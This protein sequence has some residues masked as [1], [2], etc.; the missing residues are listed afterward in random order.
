MRI[1]EVKFEDEGNNYGPDWCGIPTRYT[2]Y[3]DK[4]IVEL[5]GLSQSDREKLLELFGKDIE[6]KEKSEGF[7]GFNCHYEFKPFEVPYGPLDLSNSNDYTK[8]LKPDILKSAVMYISND[9]LPK[10]TIEFL[11][12]LN[13]EKNMNLE[14]RNI[15]YDD[16]P[17]KEVVVVIF[18]DGTKIFKHLSQGDT[19]DLRTAVA[20]A[21]TEKLFGSKTQFRKFVEKKAVK[22]DK[23]KKKATKEVNE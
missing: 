9:A 1:R 16:T 12:N 3:G 21:V 6:I 17:G 19:F 4:A 8:Y 10:E 20:F 2:R 23:K 5:E 18:T 22:I 11:K 15:Y 13:K 7:K 14:I